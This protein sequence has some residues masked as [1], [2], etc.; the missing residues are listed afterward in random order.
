MKEGVA[1]E[2]DVSSTLKI[3]VWDLW[4]T[5]HVLRVSVRLISIVGLKYRLPFQY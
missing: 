4:E 5:V 1:K 2:L 3:S